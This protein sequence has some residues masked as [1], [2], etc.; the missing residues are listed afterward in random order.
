MSLLNFRASKLY[1]QVKKHDVYDDDGNFRPTLFEWE[2]CCD[3]NVV[4]VGEANKITTPDG[5]IDFY[6]YTVNGLPPGIKKFEYGE[7]VKLEI[8]EDEEAILKV[9]GFHRY[10]LQCKLWV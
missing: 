10:Q 3:C 7:F 1:R 6:S 2:F 8:L 9:K 4:P 5:T